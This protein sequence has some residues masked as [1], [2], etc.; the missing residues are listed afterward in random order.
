MK[1]LGKC[2]RKKAIVT[3]GGGKA[4]GRKPGADK[5]GEGTQRGVKKQGRRKEWIEKK[6]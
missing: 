5:V 3:L 6:A 1:K 2:P 4:G